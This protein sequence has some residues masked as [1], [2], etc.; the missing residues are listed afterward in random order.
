MNDMYIP[1][2]SYSFVILEGVVVIVYTLMYIS[3]VGS[4]FSDWTAGPV[5]LFDQII[6][7]RAKWHQTVFTVKKENPSKRDQQM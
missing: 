1:V 5:A 3:C 7:S 2:H 4:R 6:N